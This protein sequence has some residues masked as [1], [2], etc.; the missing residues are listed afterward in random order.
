MPPHANHQNQYPGRPMPNQVPPPPHQQFPGSYQQ[1]AWNPAAGQPNMNHIPSKNGPAQTPG[2]SPRPLNH[3]KQHLLHKGGYGQSPTSPQ[4]YVNGPGMHQPMGPP[5][6]Q[7]IG[8]H[9]VPPRLQ[10]RILSLQISI[11]NLMDLQF[12]QAPGNMGP[13]FSP[14]HG[15]PTNMNTHPDGV[16]PPEASQDNGISSSGSS[17]SSQHAVTSIITTGPD[18]A[19]IDEASQ[20]STISNASAGKCYRNIF[21]F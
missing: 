6:M 12:L 13:P 15:P 2:G 19:P 11:R 7:P 14:H 16:M 18:G 5:Q 1:Q 4:S 20:Q 9:Q 3:L 10:V 17:T 8:S 21:Q